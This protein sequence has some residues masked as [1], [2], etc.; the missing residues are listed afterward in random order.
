[1]ALPKIETVRQL[2]DEALS[3]AIL[4]S[5]QTLFQLRLKQATQQLEKTHEFK[6]ERHRLAQM[7][8]IEREREFSFQM[9][10]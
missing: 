1:M 10:N 8:T 7:L 9:L 6:H 2:S 3:A 5:K 4:Q